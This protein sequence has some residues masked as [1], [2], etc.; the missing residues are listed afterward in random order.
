MN[1]G[2]PNTAHNQ[3]NLWT[4]YEFDNGVNTGFGINYLGKRDADNVGLNKIPGYTTFDGL[5]S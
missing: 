5:V 2:L 1:Q 4:V 3:A